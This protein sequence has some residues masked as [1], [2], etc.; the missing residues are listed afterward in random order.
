MASVHKCF[1]REGVA[2]RGACC[3]LRCE[4]RPPS[5]PHVKGASFAITCLSS[6]LHPST[7]A[8]VPQ[9]V[10][11]GFSG[12]KDRQV[13][14]CFKGQQ[15]DF[16]AQQVEGHLRPDVGFLHFDGQLPPILGGCTMNLVICAQS[17]TY[18]SNARLN[19][20]PCAI[21]VRLRP[22]L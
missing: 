14:D 5:Y 11:D 7:F 19:M 1:R 17:D 22:T 12:P 9:I 4:S 3:W 13:K 10:F 6:N 8:L 2:R 18:L 15:N 16:V 20:F 21:P